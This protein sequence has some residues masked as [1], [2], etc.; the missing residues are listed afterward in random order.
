M[1]QIKKYKKEVIQWVITLSVIVIL[2]TT[3]LHT[4]VL[5]GIQRIFLATGINK[6]SIPEQSTEAVSVSNKEFNAY[7]Y[8]FPLKTIEGKEVNV[9][10]L[11]GKVVFMNLWASWCP[12]CI[13]EMPGIQKLYDKIDKSKVAFVM[14]SLDEDQQ[15][16]KRFIERKKFTFPVY[17][18]SNGLPEDFYSSAIPTTFILGPDGTIITRHEGMA[19][20][21]TEEFRNYLTSLIK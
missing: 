14:L 16:G 5:G 7:K 9:K 21:D 15:K 19:D 17:F 3:G 13:A 1:F 18:P 10:S 4:E 2:F 8:D 20:F 11:K 6:P 12:P